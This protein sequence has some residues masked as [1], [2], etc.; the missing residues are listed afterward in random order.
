LF[1]IQHNKKKKKKGQMLMTKKKKASELSYENINAFF[2]GHHHGIPPPCQKTLHNYNFWNVD[3]CKNGTCKRNKRQEQQQRQN[4]RN[5]GDGES[6]GGSNGSSNGDGSGEE[7]KIEKIEKIEKHNVNTNK[8]SA[9]EEYDPTIC[10]KSFFIDG[11]Y[12]F[13][14]GVLFYSKFF[15]LII[16]VQVTWLL[17]NPSKKN[18]DKILLASSCK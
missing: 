9:C 8:V 16:A 1:T 14:K 5:G 6:T 2:A 15:G 10:L 12:R 18:K 3:K 11:I 4:T 17:I 7:E 13:F